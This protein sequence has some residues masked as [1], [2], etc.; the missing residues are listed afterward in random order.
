M[1]D[2]Y[3]QVVDI[4]PDSIAMQVGI[5][6]GFSLVALN[7]KPI[8]DILDYRWAIASEHLT[9]AMLDLEANPWE[10]DIEKDY[11]ED[12][13]LI[14]EH[15]T[16]APIK[17]CQ[18][19][20]QFCF[21]SQLPGKT[22]PTLRV[23]DDDYRLS[24]L[25]GSFITLTNLTET[26]WQRILQ[27]KPSPLYVS[28]HTT[29][30]PLRAELMRNPRADR[31]M[32]QLRTLAEHHIEMHC[33]VVLVPGINDGS[34]LDRTVNDLLSLWPAVQSVA[35]VPVGLTKHRTGLTPLRAVSRADAR[36]VIDRL[37]PL[38]RRAR[39]KLGVSFVYLA[40]EFFVLANCQVPDH[41]YYDDFPQLENGIGLVR[42]LQDEVAPLFPRVPRRLAAS[43]HVIWV[44]GTSAASILAGIARRLNQIE[45]L[46]IDVVAVPNLFFGE[47]VTV[48]GLLTGGDILRALQERDVEGKVILI[49]EV[50]LRQD[51]EDFLDDMTLDQLRAALPAA[52]I[53]VT[54]MTGQA[55]V[56]DTLGEEV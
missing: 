24:A 26:D 41:R 45:G 15:P 56:R 5:Q 1:S 29:N 21:V 46:W 37:L 48:A 6:P 33:Q 4:V 20:C 7:Q 39:R 3:P 55:L 19:N 54:S 40:D 10:I 43:R 16:I 27:A 18:N 9:L 31:I 22:R 30:G 44:T 2:A 14:F 52:E 23:K 28:V 35:V 8:G 13:G 42:R 47:S 49:P 32:Q 11:G 25:H 17:H 51:E 34:E 36:A 12:L 53:V 38:A 50:A